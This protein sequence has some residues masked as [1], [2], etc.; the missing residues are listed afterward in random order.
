MQR[1]NSSRDSGPSYTILT[2]FCR[3]LAVFRTESGELAAQGSVLTTAVSLGE[4]GPL[5]T[6]QKAN[7]H[8]LGCAFTWPGKPYRLYNTLVDFPDHPK[9]F[10]RRNH[11]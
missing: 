8:H 3:A 5:L 7:S 9:S 6:T 10:K 11:Q 2:R 1:K 4:S